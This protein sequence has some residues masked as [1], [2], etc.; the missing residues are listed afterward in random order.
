MALLIKLT[1]IPVA[2]QSMNLKVEV[3]KVT[4]QVSKAQYEVFVLLGH[5]V[6]RYFKSINEAYH[7]ITLVGRL[8]RGIG[9]IVPYTRLTIL[10]QVVRSPV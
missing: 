7:N 8:N 5:E 2:P 10:R 9:C 3:P 6:S 4:L 1:R